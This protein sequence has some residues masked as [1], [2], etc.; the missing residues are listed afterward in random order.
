MNSP[1]WQVIG[2]VSAVAFGFAVVLSLLS[3]FMFVSRKEK[4]ADLGKQIISSFGGARNARLANDELRKRRES[5][6]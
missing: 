2:N 6:E 3:K 5:Q 4:I 1:L